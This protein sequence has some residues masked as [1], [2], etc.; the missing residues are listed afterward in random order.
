MNSLLENKRGHAAAARDVDKS[1]N[2]PQKQVSRLFFTLS[3]LHRLRYEK[4]QRKYFL[5]GLGELLGEEDE[6]RSVFLQTL[7]VLLKGLNALVA[8]TIIDGDTDGPGEVL[9]ETGRFDLFQ[10]EATPE[11]LL[12]VVLNGRAS[13]DGP[14]LGGRPRGDLGSE[15]L[16]RVLAPDLPRRL[17]EPRL[18]AVL[19]I[20]LEMRVLNHVVVPH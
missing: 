12:L 3:S 6:L 11:S 9:V 20:L 2:L 15:S 18:D 7:D 8:A 19:P 1:L 4:T 13:D 14:E 5:M 17:V 16:S 10:S